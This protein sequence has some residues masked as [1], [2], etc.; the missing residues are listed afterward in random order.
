[1]K[2]LGCSLSDIRGVF[3]MEAGTIGFSGGVIG[4][5]ISY[6]ISFIINHYSSGGGGDS[7]FGMTSIGGSSIIP[8]WLAVGA[9][10]FATFVGL[11]S[12]FSPANRAVK[13]SALSAI[14]NDG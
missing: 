12:G 2:V 11:I 13:I 14:K 7:Y 10:L 6:I 8:W 3:L 1:M 5:I 4:V 9:V